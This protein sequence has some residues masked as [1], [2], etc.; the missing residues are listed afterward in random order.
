MIKKLKIILSGFIFIVV[1]SGIFF[2]C[3]NNIEYG[4]GRKPTKTESGQKNNESDIG[5]KLEGQTLV[6]TGSTT[7]LE[8]SNKWSEEFFKE[9]GGMITINGGGSGEGIAALIN[10]TTDIANSSRKIKDT[11]VQSAE[12]NKVEIFE[13]P[14]LYDGIAV[15]VSKNITVKELT[16][17]QLSK[18]Y[19]G[20]IINWKEVG[21][22]DKEIILF[23]RDTNS[24]TGEYFLEEIIQLGKTK[25]ENDYTPMTI[26]LNSNAEI[27]NNILDTDNCIGY[28]SLGFIGPDINILKIK[29][30]EVSDSVAP[31]IEAV[32]DGSYPIS[33]ELYAYLNENNVS[34]IADAYIDFILSEKGQKVGLEAGFVPIN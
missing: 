24:G 9:Y 33:R 15:I 18:I 17:E 19:T 13:V 14:I 7:L 32:Q 8:V 1:I 20:E 11:E 22:P 2:G 26:R 34:E 3:S 31:S 21:G 10:G 29:K 6:V 4:S 12:A 5:T 27:A 28:I 16:I 23:A 30:N 25:K